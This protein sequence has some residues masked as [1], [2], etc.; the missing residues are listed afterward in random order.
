MFFYVIIN[1]NNILREVITIKH[2]QIFKT[3]TSILLLLSIAVGFSACNSTKQNEEMVL[4]HLSEKYNEKFEI[5]ELIDTDTFRTSQKYECHSLSRPD[6]TFIVSKDKNN[7]QDGYFGILAQEKCESILNRIASSKSGDFKAYCRIKDQTF[8]EVYNNIDELSSYISKSNESEFD[9]EFY[10]FV[11]DE[12]K[13]DIDAIMEELKQE[14]PK[15]T[16]HLN[17]VIEDQLNRINE[18]NFG[19]YYEKT[20]KAYE[21][22]VQ[23]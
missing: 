19:S 9:I 14:I 1:T 7:Y 4:T 17:L 10:M 12:T 22:T 8:N 15:Y 5:D 11:V 6:K 21:T 2:K 23:A 16:I 3:I 13:C 20:M 18:D